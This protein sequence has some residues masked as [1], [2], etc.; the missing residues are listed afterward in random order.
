MKKIFALLLVALFGAAPL[1]ADDVADVKKVIVKDCELSAKGD[2]VGK[3]A[4]YAPDYTET[5]SGGKTADYKQAKRLVLALDG[6]HPEEFL[7]MAVTAEL[8]VAEPPSELMAKIREA[9]GNPEFVKQYEAAVPVI[10]KKHREIYELQLK[11]LKFVSVKVEGGEAT[12]VT[13][14]DSLDPLSGATTHKTVTS[15]L[16]KV[17]GSWKIY[18][19][20]I[21]EG[22]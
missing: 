11:T 6:K 12:V 17:D 8:N 13:E 14:C 4:L 20:V 22:K 10:I 1:F 5:D 16:H 3:L 7:L 9:A 2:L 21:A 19:C 15:S 18:R